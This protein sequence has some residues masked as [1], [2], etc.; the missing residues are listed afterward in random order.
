MSHLTENLLDL[1]EE[2]L[3]RIVSMVVTPWMNLPLVCTYLNKVSMKYVSSKTSAV[4][5]F[6]Y[7]YGKPPESF[8]DEDGT[9]MLDG[10]CDTNAI[11]RVI[12]TNV[13]IDGFSGT[14]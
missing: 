9:W 7:V 5:I 6:E 1:P 12:A 11:A 8:L 2:M 10:K 14:L 4:E 13:K 3:D